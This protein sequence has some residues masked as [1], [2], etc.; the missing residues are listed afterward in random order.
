M[1]AE[2]YSATNAVVSRATLRIEY[3]DGRVREFDVPTPRLVQFTIQQP[4][5]WAPDDYL[6]CVPMAPSSTHRV[7]I[8]LESSLRG[9]AVTIT[10]GQKRADE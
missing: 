8:V 10:D 5:P 1:S 9:P 3:L 2:G 4:D 7:E 6:W